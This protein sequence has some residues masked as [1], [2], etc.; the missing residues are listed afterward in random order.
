MAG[1][2]KRVNAAGGGVYAWQ[3]RVVVDSPSVSGENLMGSWEGQG[4]R[5][6]KQ[7]EV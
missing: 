2:G 6:R 5:C 3:G 1:K 4:S 7:E